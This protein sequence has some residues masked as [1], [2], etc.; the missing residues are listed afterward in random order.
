MPRKPRMQDV[1]AAGDMLDTCANMVL[2][3]MCKQTYSD[4]EWDAKRR[5]LIHAIDD[6]RTAKEPGRLSPLL[7]AG[8]KDDAEG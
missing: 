5:A 1:L 2:L 3:V 6:W 4:P 7:Q 8:T